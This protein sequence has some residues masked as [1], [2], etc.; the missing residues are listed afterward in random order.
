VQGWHR[1]ELVLESMRKVSIVRDPNDQNV[2]DLFVVQ[3]D[4]CLFLCTVSTNPNSSGKSRGGIAGQLE[5]T[6][7]A[8]RLQVT[9]VRRTRRKIGGG[10]YLKK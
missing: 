5:N 8:S 3:A 7:N 6:T 1:C 4:A 2:A 10:A 9:S